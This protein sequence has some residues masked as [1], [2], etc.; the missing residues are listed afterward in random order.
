MRSGAPRWPSGTSHCVP[1]PWRCPCLN[2]W[3]GRR[4]QCVQDHAASRGRV[5]EP[6]RTS[7]AYPRP[8]QHLNSP[9]PWNLPQETRGSG[10][11]AGATQARSRGGGGSHWPPL[12]WPW[13]S[14]G[15]RPCCV[16][17]GAC[18]ESG[19][20]R[21][22][23][24]VWGRT[25]ELPNGQ[26]NATPWALPKRA[27]PSCARPCLNSPTNVSPLGHMYRPWGLWGVA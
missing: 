24:G 25:C 22:G 13:Y 1:T 12:H 9:R 3:K 23:G 26:V 17:R 8:S 6:L 5:A 27:S 11:G 4:D 19:G 20:W 10:A 16:R 2:W 18:G 14:Q 21:S 15:L 7:P